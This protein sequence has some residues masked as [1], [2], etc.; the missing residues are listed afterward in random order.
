M[1]PKSQFGSFFIAFVFLFLLFRGISLL[2]PNADWTVVMLLTC[3]VVVAASMFAWSL[4]WKTT[5]STAFR[6][7]G[8]GLPD[9]RTLGVAALL[10]F[11]LVAFIPI[12]AASTKADIHLQGNW[13]WILLG[14]LTGVGIT[15][16]TLFR[17]FVFNSLRKN[18]PFWKAATVSMIFFGG[19]HL[20]LLFWLPIPVAIAAI[21]L[22]IISAYPT[23]YLFENGNKTIWPSAILHSAALATNLF[24]IPAGIVTSFSLIWIGVVLFFLFLVFVAGKVFRLPVQGEVYN[25]LPKE[26]DADSRV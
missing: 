8:L 4:V 3:V 19:M 21:M 2:M 22:A 16:E 11:L 23:A 15:E 7:I 24:V 26:Q 9:G 17:G 1:N 6:S 25:R 13:P 18:R 14:I 20:L 5:L 10:A 12:Y